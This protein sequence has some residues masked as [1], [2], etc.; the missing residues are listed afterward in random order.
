MSLAILAAPG[1]VRLEPT[2]LRLDEIDV[3]AEIA[4]DT[5]RPC[6]AVAIDVQ[7]RAVD[8]IRQLGLRV[9]NVAVTIPR[10][11]GAII[12]GPKMNGLS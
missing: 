9:G 5:S 8:L 6:S 3:R 2:L 12:H 4:V 10:G 7:R 1:A 11:R